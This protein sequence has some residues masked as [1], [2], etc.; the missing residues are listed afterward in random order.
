MAN[1][2]KK[3]GNVYFVLVP[4]INQKVQKMEIIASQDVAKMENGVQ[5]APEHTDILSPNGQG[6][7][8]LD[9]THPNHARRMKAMEVVMKKRNVGGKPPEIVGP[10]NTSAEAFEKMHEVRPKTD[11][12]AANIATQ[13]A[14]ILNKKTADQA[15]EIEELKAKLAKAGTK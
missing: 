4:K 3:E 2:A 15:K 14:E 11:S 9:V 7:F 6:L 1:E 10:F 12:E 8:I 5:V 13:K